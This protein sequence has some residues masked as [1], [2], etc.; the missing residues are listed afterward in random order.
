MG[1][2][3]DYRL[4]DIDVRNLE[5]IAQTNGNLQVLR[6]NRDWSTILENKTRIAEAVG[7]IGIE[8]TVLSIEEAQAITSGDR[9][10]RI[11]EKERREFEAYFDTLQFIRG[12]LDE[13]LTSGL[14]LKIH[15]K[16]TRGDEKASP[17]KIR[18]EQNYIKRN[19]EV[20][21]TPPPEQQLG[22]LLKEFITWFNQ[23]SDDKYMSP[24]LA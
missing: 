15:E 12:E 5:F 4:E 20:V 2:K 10:V 13:E 6:M 18:T 7:S 8:G 17:G 14:L 1:F 16:I 21:F 19:G 22:F 11:G 9:S 23:A 24:I 3:I